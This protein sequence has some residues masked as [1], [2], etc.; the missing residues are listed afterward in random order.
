MTV[1][2]NVPSCTAQSDATSSSTAQPGLVVPR[3]RRPATP[4]PT[5]R[6]RPDRDGAQHRR[7][8]WV[9]ARQGSGDS[10]AARQHAAQRGVAVDEM[11]LE[12]AQRCA[13]SS[14]TISTLVDHPVHAAGN[15]GH[16]SD[17][18]TKRQGLTERPPDRRETGRG[19]VMDP[20]RQ[21]HQHQRA[22]KQPVHC[23]RSAAFRACARRSSARAWAAMIAQRMRARATKKTVTPSVLCSENSHALCASCSD[24][25]VGQVVRR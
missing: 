18:G 2:C 14:A 11:M 10:A 25:V 1:I 5:E 6:Q 23:L 4:P 13:A 7:A 16:G 21:R 24:G 12:R 20:A 8:P 3:H 22:V 19:R 17:F 15:L 9:P